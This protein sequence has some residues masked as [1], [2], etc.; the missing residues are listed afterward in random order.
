MRDKIIELFEYRKFPLLFE[1]AGKKWE[2]SSPFVE[3]LIELQEK[4]YD[5]DSILESDWDIDPMHLSE[6]WKQI[7]QCQLF[8]DFSREE[9]VEWCRE[10]LKYQSH[11]LALRKGISPL[12]LDMEYFYYFKSCD[13]KLLRK[14]IYEQFAELHDYINLSD[15]KL[16]DL[17]TEINDDVMDLHEDCQ[18]YNGNAFLIS[19]VQDGKELTRNKFA[20]FLNECGKKNE[21]CHYNTDI[22]NELKNWVSNEVDSTLKLMSQRIEE[23]DLDTLAHSTLFSKFECLS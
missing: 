23:S 7:N 2:V 20:D 14:L 21:K 13:V 18:Y 17:V 9:K 22:K 3:S 1:A 12:G 16:F 10:I 15:W 8:R 5:L 4:I 19:M 6:Q 11:E